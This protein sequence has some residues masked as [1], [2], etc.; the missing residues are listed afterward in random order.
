MLT[1]VKTIK[2]IRPLDE[3]AM[4]YTRARWNTLGKPLHSLGRLE[5]MVTQFAGIYRDNEPRMNKKA[6]IVMAADNGV[7]AEGVTQ[8]VQEVTKTVT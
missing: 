3:D 4:A 7:V 1:L 8:T 5:E 6:V 2:K